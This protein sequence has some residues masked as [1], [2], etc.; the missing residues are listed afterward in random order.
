MNYKRIYDSLM[1]RAVGR[2]LEGYYETHHIIP[3]CLG[4][5]DD[6]TNLVKLTYREHFLAHWI[7]HRLY[8]NDKLLAYAFSAMKFDKYGHRS[9]WNPSSRQLEELKLAI[10]SARTGTPHSDETKEKISLALKKKTLCGWKPFNG[11]GQIPSDDTKEKMREAKLGRK[12]SEE[13]KRAISEGKRGWY[14]NNP[15]PNKGKSTIIKA[16][17][18]RSRE[19]LEKRKELVKELYY[20]NTPITEIQKEANISRVA[21]YK[22][23]NAEGWVR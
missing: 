17:W 7:L 9:K 23:I 18:D 3:R 4:G 20:N 14:K 15:N 10:I 11:K 16:K 13:E 2:E 6:A 22:W 8:P 12:L 21:I 5:T 19:G 1:E